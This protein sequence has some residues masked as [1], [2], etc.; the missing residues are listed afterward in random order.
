MNC[1]EVYSNNKESFFELN[2]D[3]TQNQELLEDT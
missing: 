1:Y 2:T 3:H